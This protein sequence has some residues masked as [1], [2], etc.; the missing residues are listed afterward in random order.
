VECRHHCLVDSQQAIPLDNQHG[1][2]QDS[3]QDSQAVNRRPFRPLLPRVQQVNQQEHLLQL[4]RIFLQ[5]N[6]LES[7]LDYHLESQQVIRQVSQV[8]NQVVTHQANRRQNLH[9][10]L[11]LNQLASPLVSPLV[12]QHLHQQHQQVNQQVNP[13]HQLLCLH[14]GFR[15]LN[16]H[17][18]HLV[19]RLQH[20]HRNLQPNHQPS[21][22]QYPHEVSM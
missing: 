21:L 11:Q 14:Q 22:H 7:Q 6:H 12:N 18:N 9:L 10:S 19:Y 20:H 4:Q 16:P 13:Q 3:L 15:H 2:L 17:L 5:F 1:S 8:V